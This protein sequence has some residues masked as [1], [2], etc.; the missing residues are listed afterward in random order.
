MNFK[1]IFNFDENKTY[2]SCN[3]TLKVEVSFYEWTNSNTS[4]L[5]STISY[6]DKNELWYSYK[7][8]N[9]L[10]GLKIEIKYNNIIIKEEY[11]KFKTNTNEKIKKQIL[12]LN[13]EIG[14]GDNLAATPI[15]KKISEI[16]N[17]KVIILTYIPSAFI[18]NP[19]IEQII[20]IKN[21]LHQ[22]LNLYNTNYYN[23]HQLFNLMGTNWRLV[24]HKQICAYNTG[25]QLLPEE[26]DMEFYPDKFEQIDN[27]PERFICINPSETEPERTWGVENWQKFINLI[28]EYIPV[29]AIGKE[30]YLDPNLKKIFSNIEIKNGLNLLNKSCQN[31]LSQAYHIISKSETFVTMNNGLY[32]L[33]LCNLDNHITELSTSWNTIYYR[34]RKGIKNYNLD[35]IRGT[36]NAEC[37]SNPKISIDQ[38]G[39]TQILKSGICYLNKPTYECHPTPEQ[40]YES[41]LKIIFSVK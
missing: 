8:L 3:S 7:N 30:T 2:I 5:Y 22:L 29:V 18:N 33:A 34:T 15:I 35:Y 16:Y 23:I 27:L 20:P 21:N 40:V 1:I 31:T 37:L 11:F 24:D 26:L 14:I 36:C 12:V 9:N 39:S 6:F 32:I 19:Y 10:N 4:L 38:T 13:S 25:I 28:Q 17:Q 41:V